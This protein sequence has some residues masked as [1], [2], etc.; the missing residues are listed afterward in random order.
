MSENTSTENPTEDA[1]PQSLRE[2]LQESF[3]ELRAVETT[4]PEST[5]AEPTELDAHPSTDEVQEAEYEV[6]SEAEAQGD[7]DEVIHAPEHWSAEDRETFEGLPSAAQQYLLKREKQYEQGI[8]QKAEELKPLKEAFGPYRD[9]LK[10]R[11]VDEATAVRTW[12]AAQQMLDT[13]PV[14]G[15]RTLIQ[16]FTPDVQRAITAQFGV[17]E[18][19]DSEGDD[20]GSDPEVQKLRNE[21]SQLKRQNSQQN[22]QYQQ[23]RQQEALEQVRQ[24]REAVGEDGKPLHPHF[25]EVSDEM[26]A[27]LSAG[28]VPDLK[29]AYERAV[30][31][32]PAYR[33]E[34][35]AK[36]R[37]DAEREA[38]RR[39]EEAAKKA[40]KTA[41]AVNGKGSVPPPAPKQRTL[42]DELAEAYKQSVRGEL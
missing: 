30:W 36:Q 26:R 41:K 35:A 32:L 11:G 12:V 25:D 28:V 16:Q 33:E 29:A 17:T 20:Y 22:T 4:E 15:F 1:G 23:L 39:R 27:Y 40:K 9:I 31:S 13:D 24:F 14:N 6:P 42:R 38:A 37:Q 19:A 3:N 21:L 34:F 7:D 18:S 10:M 8:Q 5:D 2:A